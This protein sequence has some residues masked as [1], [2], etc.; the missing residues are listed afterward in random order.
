[1]AYAIRSLHKRVNY[2]TNEVLTSKHECVFNLFASD[3]HAPKRL[4]NCKLYYKILF[5]TSFTP[6]FFSDIPYCTVLRNLAVCFG[7][8][9]VIVNCVCENGPAS[10]KSQCVSKIGVSAYARPNLVTGR[11]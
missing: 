7:N 8:L 11:K 5:E 10:L 3:L 6:P 4:A 1:V 2:V 9:S